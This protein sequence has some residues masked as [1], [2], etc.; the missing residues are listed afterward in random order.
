MK[1]TTT[2]ANYPNERPNELNAKTFAS[3]HY[4]PIRTQKGKNLQ[5]SVQIQKHIKSHNEKSNAGNKGSS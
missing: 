4:L 1:I 2:K 5:V 3:I